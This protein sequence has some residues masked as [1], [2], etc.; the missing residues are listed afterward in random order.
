MFET[1]NAVGPNLE[2]VLWIAAPAANAATVNPNGI[3]TLLPNGEVNIL[4]IGNSGS[5][6]GTR[7]L[8]PLDCNVLDN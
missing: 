4:L 2:K 7:R 1:I 3:K 8:N 6:N 5:S